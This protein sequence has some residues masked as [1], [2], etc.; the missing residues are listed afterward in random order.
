MRFLPSNRMMAHTL[1]QLM[2]DDAKG[3][4]DAGLVLDRKIKPDKFDLEF[5]LSDVAEG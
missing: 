5:P 1:N 2:L 3:L 4:Q